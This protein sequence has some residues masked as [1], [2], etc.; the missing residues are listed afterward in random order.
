MM[1]GM[2]IP[3]NSSS[4][5]RMVVSIKKKWVKAVR[6][7]AA[8]VLRRCPPRVAAQLAAKAPIKSEMN[9]HSAP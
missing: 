9:S 8:Q 4:N 3:R 6:R 7:C 5:E 2:G 1:M